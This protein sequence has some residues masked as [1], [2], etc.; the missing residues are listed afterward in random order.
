MLL[1]NFFWQFVWVSLVLVTWALIRYK[2]PNS[3]PGRVSAVL[4]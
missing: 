2:W 3:L 1:V 4:V